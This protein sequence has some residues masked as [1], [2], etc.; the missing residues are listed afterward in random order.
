MGIYHFKIIN[1][2]DKKGHNKVYFH[3]KFEWVRFIF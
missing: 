1:L 3:L 2:T